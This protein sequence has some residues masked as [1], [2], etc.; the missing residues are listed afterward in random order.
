MARAAGQSARGVYQRAQIPQS[1][2]MW[3]GEKKR[4]EKEEEEVVCSPI[5]EGLMVFE[6]MSMPALSETAAAWV[7]LE[8]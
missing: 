2:G 1:V 8:T 5:C 3:K 7:T 4:C 6:F